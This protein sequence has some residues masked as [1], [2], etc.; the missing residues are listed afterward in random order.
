M[1]YLDIVNSKKIVVILLLHK[2]VESHFFQIASGQICL[3]HAAKGTLYF[4]GGPDINQDIL[5]LD[6]RQSSHI[7]QRSFPSTTRQNQPI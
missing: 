5:G 4:C 7:V 1:Y 3:A 2:K 6:A